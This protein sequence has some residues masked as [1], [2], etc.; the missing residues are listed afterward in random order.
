FYGKF[1]DDVVYVGDHQGV[2]WNKITSSIDEVIKL[3]TNNP[4]YL[5]P[6]LKG[7]LLHYFI[8]YIHP[9]FDGNGRT[10]R[11]LFY[12]KTIKNNLKF[13]EL[14]SVSA[15]LK[16]HGK[17]YERSF[18]QVK[19]NDLDI[20]YFI[21]FCLDSLIHAVNRVEKK[22]N[23]LIDIS[24]LQEKHKLK[25]NQISLLQRMALHKFVSVSIN[26]YAAE[27]GKSREI[28]RRELKM[29]LTLEFLIEKKVGKKF[30]YYINSPKLKVSV[31]KELELRKTGT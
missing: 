15:N 19:S 1:R 9:F 24:C 17:R 25:G 29:L 26:S 16:E 31:K 13:V 3:T 12:Y 7:I 5:H 4:R 11:T 18:D 23:Y 27:I 22:V 21:D 10:A 8:G 28:A 20:T 2:E 30:V 14:L 6:L